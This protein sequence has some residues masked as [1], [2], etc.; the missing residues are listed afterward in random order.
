MPCSRAAG[1]PEEAIV[2]GEG[3]KATGGPF[4]TITHNWGTSNTTLFSRRR[5]EFDGGAVPASLRDVW[6][7][8]PRRENTSKVT[9]SAA[10]DH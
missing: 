5:Q 7:I 8:L 6:D 1:D 3:N 10:S 9:Q 4:S 2:L